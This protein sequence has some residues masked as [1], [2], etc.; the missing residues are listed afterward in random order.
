MKICHCRPIPMT[1]FSRGTSLDGALAAR[2]G[3]CIKLSQIDKII[4]RYKEDM[5]V[6]VGLGVGWERLNEEAGKHGFSFPPNPGPR[7]TIHGTHIVHDSLTCGCELF[8]YCD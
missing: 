2:G 7:A 6:I 3:I 4:V 1:P 5:D 8:A